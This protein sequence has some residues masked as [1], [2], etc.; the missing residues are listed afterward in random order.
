MIFL[1]DIPI[2]HNG[3]FVYKLDTDNLHIL[4]YLNNISFKEIETEESKNSYISKNKKILKDLPELKK[5]ISL[6]I[7]DLIKNIL[8]FDCKYIIYNSWGT[9]T[10]SNGYSSSHTHSNSWIS[11]VYYPSF[12]KEFKIKFYNDNSN[13][14]EHIVKN[15]NDYNI[16]N[17]KNWT[18][19][20]DKNQLILF[21][22]NLRHKILFNNSNE[23]RYSISFNILPNKNFGFED[24]ECFFNFK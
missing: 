24:S 1:K 19:L 8:K 6:S 18:I 22:S 23:E 12:N 2:I 16:Y 15:E 10:L 4:N 17:S 9:K 11:G 5:E 21:F 14:F 3:I 13:Q 20:P 7:E